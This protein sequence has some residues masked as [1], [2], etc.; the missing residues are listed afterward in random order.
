M[1]R[2]IAFSILFCLFTL[3]G[4]AQ[5]TIS[6]HVVDSETGEPV[7]YVTIVVG[8]RFRLLSNEEGNFTLT[9]DQDEEVFFSRV[10]YEKMKLN[11]KELGNEIRLQPMVKSL[12]EITV[13]PFSKDYILKRCI[14]HLE[15][16]YKNGKKK[17]CLYF[18]RTIL[19][20]EN[21]NEML[22]AFIK[23]HSVVNLRSPHLISGIVSQDRYRDGHVRSTN[24]HHL[25][26]LGPMVYH[27]PFW[28]YTLIPFND[29]DEVGSSYKVSHS[30]LSASDNS[31]IYK[32]DLKFTGRF[33]KKWEGHK[34]VVEGSLYISA[35]DFRLLQFDGTVRHLY[36]RVRESKKTYSLSKPTTLNIHIQ[37]QYENGYA[38]VVNLSLQGKSEDMKYRTVLFNVPDSVVSKKRG[39]RVGE[40]LV[41]AIT[42]AKK[43]SVLWANTGI[44]QRTES[45]ER[46]AFGMSSELFMKSEHPRFSPAL[47]QIEDVK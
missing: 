41:K 35:K 26:E 3:N 25:I 19:A 2:H 4:W 6:A 36:L 21:G 7:P 39:V 34:S 24:V 44:I 5:Q 12:T 38:E 23:S 30:T 10:G 15:N 16:D 20:D 42:N 45:E 27:S 37:Y 40:N 18:S 28:K 43:D 17:D 29:W 14:E 1:I 22:E 32:F 31:M 9:T 11:V 13:L 46:L 8:N 47:E 33:P